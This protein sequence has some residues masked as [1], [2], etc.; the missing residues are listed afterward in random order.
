MI[1]KVKLGVNIDHIATLRNARGEGRPDV[2]HAA[3]IVAQ[4]GGDGITVHLR[5]D[6]RHIKDADVFAI[7]EQITL[8]LN[9]ELAA[10]DEMLQIALKVK[11][12]SCCI[13][14]EKREELTTEGGLDVVSRLEELKDFSSSLKGEGIKTSLFID[15]ENAQ[16]EAA[17]EVGAEIIEFHTGAYCNASGSDRAAELEKIAGSCEYAAKLGITCH[18][19]HGLDYDTV[20][21]IVKIPQIEELNIGHFLI[22][23]SVFE[24]L[25]EV[26]RKMKRVI[27]GS[28]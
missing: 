28:I 1:R 26:I 13:V 12:E 3:E 27:E 16:I 23:E 19:G 24:G 5:E 20:P 21:D 17:K 4:S 25:P 8:P 15:A 11:P 2:L 9:L 18:A 10:T 6:R 22:A 7:S 14:P